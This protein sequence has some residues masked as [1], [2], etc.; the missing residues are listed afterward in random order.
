VIVDY[1]GQQIFINHPDNTFRDELVHFL[2]SNE[3]ETFGVDEPYATTISNRRE[4]ILF[5]H[6]SEEANWNWQSFFEQIRIDHP[7][8][9]IAALGTGKKPEGVDIFFDYT[10]DDLRGKI[11]SYLDEVNA[12]GHRRFIR[13]GSQTASI[14][15]FDYQY[16][17]M[18][19]AGIIHDISIADSSCTFNPEPET[20]GHISVDDL[21]LTLPE[22][23]AS[24]NGRFTS[25]RVVAGQKIH[26]LQFIGKISDE[27]KIHIQDFIYSSLELKL[28]LH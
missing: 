9:L 17:G 21:H 2:R 27:C 5:L 18:R 20:V 25:G 10:E 3:F 7:D 8:Q 23:R 11:I 22:S 16:E 19:Y 24:I 4:S 1:R 15:T 26:V 13:F 12:R 28:S 6:S 14:A